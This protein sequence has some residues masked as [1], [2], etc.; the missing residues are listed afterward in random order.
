[1]WFVRLGEEYSPSLLTFRK[2]GEL[3]AVVKML[4]TASSVKLKFKKPFITLYR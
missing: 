2:V 3:I 4:R 1:M